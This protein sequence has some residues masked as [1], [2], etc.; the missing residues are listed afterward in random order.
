MTF[1]FG[2]RGRANVSPTDDLRGRLHSRYVRVT[3]RARPQ[4][5]DIVW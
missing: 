1:R 3:F 4:P 2:G 5:P